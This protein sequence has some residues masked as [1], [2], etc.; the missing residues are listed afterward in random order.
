MGVRPHSL[1]NRNGRAGTTAANSLSNTSCSACADHRLARRGAQAAAASQVHIPPCPLSV[2]DTLRAIFYQ[3]QPSPA[4]LTLKSLMGMPLFSTAMLDA[5]HQKMLWRKSIVPWLYV[6][7]MPMLCAAVPALMSTDV[8][9]AAGKEKATKMRKRLARS[10]GKPNVLSASS[11]TLPPAG[12]PQLAD[13]RGGGGGGASGSP[14]PIF[15]QIADHKS[16]LQRERSARRA[17]A[18]YAA[19]GSATLA[20]ADHSPAP[21]PAPVVTAAAAVPPPPPPSP[22]FQAEDGIRDG[23]S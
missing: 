11:P 22:F 23:I 10:V 7:A 14:R 8:C 9:R 19:A 16:A 17:A 21:A 15:A 12:V 18:V 1:R 4:P 13:L 3:Q 5:K 20:L 6:L 2:Q